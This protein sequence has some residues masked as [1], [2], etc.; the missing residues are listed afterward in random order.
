MGTA[1]KVKE[2]PT[3]IRKWPETQAKTQFSG[4]IA[5]SRGIPGI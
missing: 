3:A 1:Q 4:R 2:P 5:G